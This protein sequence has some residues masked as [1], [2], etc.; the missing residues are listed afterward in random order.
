VLLKLQQMYG[1]IPRLQ[2]G[3]MPRAARRPAY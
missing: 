2:V 1:L 3:N